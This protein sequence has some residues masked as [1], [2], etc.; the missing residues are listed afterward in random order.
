[1]RNI[2]LLAMLSTPLSAYAALDT[3]GDGIPDNMDNCTEVANATQTDSDND[4]YGNR[5]DPDFND[6]GTV[7]FI[8]LGFM[9]SV[10]YTG[11]AEADLDSS[12]TVNFGDLGIL[13]SYFY[14]ALHRLR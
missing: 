11:N 1:M 10:F 3:D 9:K 13:K 6:D 12:G 2:L 14:K 4:G 8:D 5:C 7:N